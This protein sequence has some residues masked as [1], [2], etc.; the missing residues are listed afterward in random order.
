ME[1]YAYILN[2]LG[3][4]SNKFQHL[5]NMDIELEE[6]NDLSEETFETLTGRRKEQIQDMCQ[7]R[8]LKYG[9]NK[10]DLVTRLIQFHWNVV[11]GNIHPEEEIADY[12]LGGLMA[13]WMM[14]PK[15]TTSMKVGA[16]NEVNILPQLQIGKIWADISCQ[17]SCMKGKCTSEVRILN[18]GC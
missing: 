3:I 8:N 10:I 13:S 11:I 12:L 2:F 5:L 6:V 14:K 15:M 17:L 18:M 1:Q 7:I 9:G 16:L 4:R